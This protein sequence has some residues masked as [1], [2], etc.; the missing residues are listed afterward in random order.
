MKKYMELYNYYRD[1]IVAG[2]LKEGDRMPS[3]RRTADSL[4][5]S[6]T[7]VENAYFALQADGYILAAPQSGY[8]VAY[9]RELSAVK[10]E[11]EGYLPSSRQQSNARYDL[12]SG[13][14]DRDSFDLKLWQRYIRNALRQEDRLCSYSDV[15]GEPD[16]REALADYIREKRNVM[17]SPDRIVVGAGVQVLLNMLASL[18]TERKTVSF[19]D[20]SFDQGM[21]VFESYGYEVTTR[22]K[23]ADIIYVCPSHMTRFGD[24]MP[25]KRRMELVSYSAARGSLVIEDDFDND[26]LY[27]SR[28]TPSLFALSAE[29]NVVYMGSFANVLLPG[30]R[31]SFMVLPEPL[32]KAFQEKAHLFAQ[33]ASK[34][35][36]IALTGFIRDGHIKSQIR[37]IRRHQ[38][39]KARAF[40]EQLHEAMPEFDCEVSENGLQVKLTLPYT[41]PV[42]R[43]REKGVSVYVD[44]YQ[45]GI[46]KLMLSPSALT[47]AEIPLAVQ[48]LK[49][50]IYE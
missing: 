36:Q 29:G 30:I 11:E 43:F 10:K 9:H 7:T 32:H 44:S 40:Y 50:A 6:K 38:T 21:S 33:T 20:G 31:I 24:V 19:P 35:E 27:A 17:T 4:G 28:P 1:R 16:L 18:I 39:A 25:I 5:F 41:G 37:K 22:N 15:Q 2:Q 46:L 8:F 42:D 14:A 45:N 3:I 34:T 13:D 48:A 23:D 26:F 47:Q 49:E 12:S